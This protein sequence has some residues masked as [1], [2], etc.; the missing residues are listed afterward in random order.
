[1]LKVHQPAQEDASTPKLTRDKLPTYKD[2][3]WPFA[4]ILTT[5]GILGFTIFGFNRTPLQMLLIV[6][7]GMILEVLMALVARRHL[8]FPLSAYISC[9][10]LA[11]LLNY[12]HQNW[13]LFLPVYLAIASKYLLT[14]ER[15]HVFNPSMFGVAMS[16]L[17]VGDL[18]TSAPAY[19]W[20]GGD[21]TMTAFIIMAALMLFVF[22]I[23]K[24]WLIFSFLFFYAL[25]TLARAY[26]MRHHIPPQMLF[27]GTLSAP[28]FFIF[29]FY[30]ITDPATSPKTRKGQ[31]AL[32]FALAAVDL[33]LHL[34][35]SVFTFFYAALAIAAAKYAYLHS[36]K[37][38]R[39]GPADYLAAFK[40]PRRVLTW[41]VV[42]GLG[43]GMV[44]TYKAWI[45][46]SIERADVGFT[47]TKIPAQ[48][49]GLGSKMGKTLEQADERLLHVVKWV[50]SVGDAVAVADVNGDGL[51]DMF[52][53]R[54]LHDPDSRAALYINKGDFKFERFALPALDRYKTQEGLRRFGIIG[55]GTFVD[56]DGDGDTDL[57]AVGAFGPSVILKNELVETGRLGFEDVTAELGLKD[58]HH[59]S[60]AISF[61]DFNQDAKLDMY[62]A[63]V[64]TTHLPDYKPP[65]P[66]NIFALPKP[67]YEGDRRA[68]RFMHNGW[69]DAD[70]GGVNALYMAQPRGG[71]VRHPLPEHTETRW[72]LAICTID[73]N[74]DGWT[75]LYIAND[76]GPDRLYLNHK[77]ER[78]ESVISASYGDV[79]KDTYKGMNCTSAD[80]DRNGYEDIYISNVHAPLQAE[81]S[82]LWMIKPGL[83]P[84]H[85]EFHDEATQRNALNEERFA[86][87]AG[88]GDLNNDGWPDIVQAN[89]ML[90]DRLDYKGYKRKDYLYVNH[91]LM[92]SG[93]D[94]HTYADM[95]G[96][97]RGRTIFPNQARRALINQGDKAPGFFT[98][99]AKQIGIDD[100]DNSRGVALVDLD[101][102]GDLDLVISNQHGPVSLY[103]NELRKPNAPADHAHFVGLTLLGDGQQ[104]HRSAVG[105]RVKLTYTDKATQKPVE[106]WKE[107][108]LLTGFSGQGDSRLHWGLG[109]HDG[110]ISATI[111]W[112][113]GQTQQVEL[114]LDQYQV[115]RQ[116]QPSAKGAR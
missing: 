109:A 53:S 40:Q 27:I 35:E 96:D 50:L 66:L 46:P 6:L 5:Y 45:R 90:D 30:M 82:L 88:A 75:D 4:L 56:F 42:L 72:S 73:V 71:F 29:T 83:D 33:Y 37:L 11:L 51:Q 31:V 13:L 58:E 7:S 55:G 80:F 100:P 69:H 25:Q 77:G 115:I 1:M 101:N 2:P 48:D 79:G 76:F 61:F 26:F 9:C 110:P 57:V 74:H 81:G 63:N 99:V 64:L 20:A 113:G 97:I 49:S 52:L 103:R 28:A 70:N 59:V 62:V 67:E 104:T 47:M 34:Y 38:I 95:W 87:G 98:D 41:V 86:W 8:V 68:L 44:V 84:F 14:F 60:M 91:K 107:V 93:P 78:F 17:L 92:Q 12:S 116:A 10:S 36:K 32:G 19:Q 3:R 24:N 65:V 16:L 43:A 23:G 21:I 111:H 39:Q 114:E 18:I 89:G 102:D 112:Y 106:Q 85:P 54:P 15:K 105:T 108:R 22:K 94:I